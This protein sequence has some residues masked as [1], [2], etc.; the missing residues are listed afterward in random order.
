MKRLITAVLLCGWAQLAPAA[1]S[2]IVDNAT[3][4]DALKRNVI[5]WDVRP[6]DAYARGHVPGA[7]SIGDAA[8]VLR[9]DNTED[10]IATE[11]IEKTLG[12]AGLDPSRE[13]IVYGSRG[14]W[15][16]YFGLYTLQYF[17]GN[18]A[19][20]YHG[21]IEDWTGAGRPV[22]REAVQLPA[23]ALKLKTHAAVTVN[24]REM[25]AR[26]NDP[27]VQI[28]D[29]RTPKEFSGEDIRAIRGGHIPGA[30]NIP[31]E[32]NWIDPDTPAKLARKQ[33]A[34]NAGMSLKPV[35]ELKQLYAKLD[36]DKETIVYC[37][38]GARASETAGVLQQLGFKNVKVYDSS[39][40]G[41][42]NTLDAPANNVTFFNLGLLNSRLSAMQTRIDQL[43]KELTEAK[44]R[45]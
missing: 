43:Q 39:W 7:I 17:G 3:V 44:A 34:D 37:Q 45:N 32:H 41:Y 20:V 35:E 29:V 1:A 22:S 23:I 15:N 18:H 24:T 28:V 11:R 8:K 38:S 16:P 30:I 12:A 14:T 25:V 4:A 27:G 31:Y 19:R 5:V 9:D 10:F 26:L 21:G 33:V 40:L 13:I 42:G 2:I 6:A 36:P